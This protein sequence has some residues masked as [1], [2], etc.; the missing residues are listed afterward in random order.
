MMFFAFK[1]ITSFV[2]K[3]SFFFS[4]KCQQLILTKRILKKNQENFLL[5]YDPK[6]LVPEI[7]KKSDREKYDFFHSKNI[8]LDFLLEEEEERKT[9]TIKRRMRRN[10]FIEFQGESKRMHFSKDF[11]G[12]KNS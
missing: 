2:K 7:W 8:N 1:F 4:K 5:E 11:M 10:K 6:K 9:R 3:E 12:S